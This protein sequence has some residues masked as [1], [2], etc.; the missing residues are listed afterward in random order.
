[1]TRQADDQALRDIEAEINRRLFAHVKFWR[2]IDPYAHAGEVLNPMTD[3]EAR[4]FVTAH[5][6]ELWDTV[7][8]EQL[9]CEL[10]EVQARLHDS[11]ICT[12][13][14]GKA[15]ASTEQP[16][17]LSAPDISPSTADDQQQAA[18]GTPKPASDLQ[19]GYIRRLL[20]RI[21]DYVPG[22]APIGDPE[23]VR[24]WC[25]DVCNVDT[26]REVGEC[27]AKCVKEV[28]GTLFEM[29]LAERVRE[30]RPVTPSNQLLVDL[31]TTAELAHAILCLAVDE[32]EGAA[33]LG[34]TRRPAGLGQP[35]SER[36]REHAA[37]QTV[38]AGQIGEVLSNMLVMDQDTFRGF[39]G[40]FRSCVERLLPESTII[41]RARQ[42]EKALDELL[43]KRSAAET[44]LGR[45]RQD[46][47]VLGRINLDTHA[48][49]CADV[50]LAAVER[51]KVL[52]YAGRIVALQAGNDY[53]RVVAVEIL[54]LAL[55][56][57]NRQQVVE[58]LQEV[59]RPG[60]ASFSVAVDQ[61]LRRRLLRE[62]FA[63]LV[64]DGA[65]SL[66]S[67]SPQAATALAQR[68]GENW[69][70]VRF[71][72]ITDHDPKRVPVNLAECLCGGRASVPVTPFEEW[73]KRYGDWLA[74]QLAGGCLVELWR[75]AYGV[76]LAVAPDGP[77]GVSINLQQLGDIQPLSGTLST[78]TTTAPP[79]PGT[80]EDR[81]EQSPARRPLKQPSKKAIAVFRYRLVTGKTQTELAAD[82]RLME[83][84]GH[85]VDQGTISRWLKQ[86]KEWL[87][88][89]NVLPDLSESLDS[90]PSPMDPKWIELGERQD[91]RASRQRDR[92]NSARDE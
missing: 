41:E 58:R 69:P 59:N 33:I 31:R 44:L 6:R 79:A 7:L 35:L 88:A 28:G 45:L 1:L 22:P 32:A 17:E 77:C 60:L 18:A 65:E 68:E 21:I 27:W 50:L 2:C 37:R 64:G 90:K 84:L 57:A 83:L 66:P 49:V 39:K 16:N 61:L 38:T 75:T 10:A 70:E 14:V 82:P 15:A 87:E 52:G 8:P 20:N 4:A 30:D 54:R 25:Q 29:G 24:R 34:R 72:F 55:D 53:A 9:K 48:E 51:A 26:P 80:A 81:P 78:T 43:R 23:A 3:E 62:V 40:A 74:A 47:P 76:W 36:D 19:I 85:A 11:A 71:V 86:V 12:P 5:F 56:R 67:L 13:E 91:G 63:E 42:K 89:G 92:R 73:P 46:L